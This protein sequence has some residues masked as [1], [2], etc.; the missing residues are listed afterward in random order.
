[1]AV[2]AGSIGMARRQAEVKNET[3]VCVLNHDRPLEK[4]SWKQFIA[5]KALHMG[6][7]GGV[8]TI[9]MPCVFRVKSNPEKL[10]SLSW[11]T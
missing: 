11:M 2:D 8:L 9:L 6:V 7:L 5:L 10:L 3:T 4:S 1:M